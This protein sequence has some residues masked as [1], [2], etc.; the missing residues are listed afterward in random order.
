MGLT[1]ISGFGSLRI[2]ILVLE[3]KYLPGSCEDV[4]PLVM[5]V[6]NILIE[7]QL[8]QLFTVYGAFNLKFC[9]YVLS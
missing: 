1:R 3:R 9:I 8:S 2:E 4:L 5:I 6:Y 7:N